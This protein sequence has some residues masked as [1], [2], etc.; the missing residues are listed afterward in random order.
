MDIRG[1]KESLTGTIRLIVAHP[2]D[3][4][5]N[6]IPGRLKIRV[7][8][9]TNPN[10][11]GRVIGKGGTV[12]SSVSRILSAME[13]KGGPKIE[14][15]YVTQREVNQCEDRSFSKHGAAHR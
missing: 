9:H 15:D 3:V 14:L 10:E 8:L 1:L 11:I 13:S 2:D 4:V 5:V 12:I 6:V 7:E